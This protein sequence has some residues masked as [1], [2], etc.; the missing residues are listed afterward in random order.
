[1]TWLSIG[2]VSAVFFFATAA[3][4]AYLAQIRT[5]AEKVEDRL[6]KLE[7][8]LLQAAEHRRQQEDQPRTP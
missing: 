6:I 7:S 5:R 2:V 1:V 3:V 8:S 4:V